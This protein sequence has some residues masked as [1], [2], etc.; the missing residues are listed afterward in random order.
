MVRSGEE[1]AW[2]RG[3]MCV[4]TASPSE[5]GPPCEATSRPSGVTTVVRISPAENAMSKC[6]GA[7]MVGVGEGEGAARGDLGRAA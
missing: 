3:G 2:L 6:S 7:V 4:L 1:C 5:Q